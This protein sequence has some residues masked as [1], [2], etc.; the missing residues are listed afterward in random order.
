MIRRSRLLLPV[1][2]VASAF[3][4]TL[5]CA[6]PATPLVN[7]VDERAFFVVSVSDAPGLVRSWERTPFATTWNDPQ[8][9]KFLA[10]LRAEMK[11]DEWNAEAE[12]ATGLSLQELLALAQGE[13]LVAVPAFDKEHAKAHDAPPFLVALEVGDQAEKLE[14]LLAKAAADKSLKEETETYAGVKVTTTTLPE[15]EK[16]AEDV[17]D[18]PDTAADSPDEQPAKPAKPTTISW[19][20]VDGVWLLGGEKERVLS[21]IDAVK[22]GGVATSLGKSE[23]FLRTR[24]RVGSAQGLVFVNLPAIYPLIREAVLEAKA[25]GGMNALGIDPE[26]LFNAFAL[27]ALGEAFVAL[28]IEESRS[29]IDAGLFYAEERGLTKLL[30]YQTGAAPRP[31]WVAAKWPSVSTARFSIPKLYEGIEQLLAS[32]SPM[33]SMLVEGR[34]RAFN[35]QL[36]IDLKR[37]LVGSFGEEIVT[38]YALPPGARPGEVPAWTEMDQ[39][40]AFSLSNE[41]ALARSIDALKQVAGPAADQMFNKRDYLGSTLYTLNLPAPAPGMKAPRGFSYAIANGTLLVGIGS[42]ATVESALQGMNSHD[43]GFWKRDDIQAALEIVPAEATGVQVQDLRVMMASL[44]E[45]AVKFQQNLNEQPDSEDEEK[46]V[47][48]DVDARPDDEVIARHWGVAT[49]Y[50]IRNSDGLFSTTILAHPQK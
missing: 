43:G 24:Q 12:T 36:R 16:N 9:A 27:D 31:D 28:T 48:V 33:Y 4:A 18:K 29:R 40:L 37:D 1:F 46:T 49:G 44:V 30:A 41:Q 8:V 5:V 17:A 32:V 20:I 25:E 39:L 47:I 7:L 26:A 35:K 6:T 50:A 22:Q 42:P 23:R 34:I 11:I 13:A 38:A 21:T 3:T 19:A 15:S 45:A 10:P 14:K 2:A